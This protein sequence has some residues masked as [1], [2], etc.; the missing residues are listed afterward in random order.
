MIILSFGLLL[1]SLSFFLLIVYYTNKVKIPNFIE[2][3]VYSVVI[4][5]LRFL[6]SLS[7]LVSLMELSKIGTTFYLKKS[8]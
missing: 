2:L 8:V 3:G 6:A 4:S 7:N 1:S 5:F